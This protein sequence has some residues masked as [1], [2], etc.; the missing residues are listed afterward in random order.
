VGVAINH[1]AVILLVG[2]T[3]EATIRVVAILVVRGIAI[4]E[5]FLDGIII[6]LQAHRV[7]ATINLLLPLPILLES[8]CLQEIMERKHNLS[9]IFIASTKS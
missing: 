7:L 8:T 6:P 5:K 4:V 2:V 1:V 9:S 3:A